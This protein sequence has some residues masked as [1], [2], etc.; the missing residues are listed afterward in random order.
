MVL[1]QEEL[2]DWNMDTLKNY[3]TSS[4]GGSRGA[5]LIRKVLAADLLELRTLPSQKEKSKEI[6]RRRLLK[7]KVGCISIP[8]PK[9]IMQGWMTTIFT[10]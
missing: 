1:T 10:V 4:G 3:L 2:K 9:I 6:A 7:L 5:D 8:F